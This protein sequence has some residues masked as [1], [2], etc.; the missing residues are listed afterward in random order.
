MELKGSLVVTLA[1]IGLSLAVWFFFYVTSA[2]LALGETT[3]V[4]G[5]CAVI[6]LIGKWIW[7]RFAKPRTKNGK[8]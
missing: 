8:D 6:V 2:P 1:I 4:V 3:V 7:S 5:L